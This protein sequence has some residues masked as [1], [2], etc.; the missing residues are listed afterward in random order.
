MKKYKIETTVGVFVVIGVLCVGYLT[1]KLGEVPFFGHDTYRLYAKFTSVSGL[2]VGNTV[3][4]LGIEVGRVDALTMDQ[5]DQLAVVTMS[6]DKGV[7]VYKDAIASIRTAGLIGDR[8]VR[9]DPGGA[10]QLLKPGDTIRDTEAPTDITDLIGKYAFGDL[11]K[12][13][14]SR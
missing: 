6:V 9:I 10:E 5:E 8:Y 2:R 13:D 14:E 1:V 7:K 11:S 4:M 3:Q 12:K